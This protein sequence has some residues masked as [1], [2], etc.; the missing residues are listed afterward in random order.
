MTSRSARSAV[1]KTSPAPLRARR[2]RRPSFRC[3]RAGT[4]PPPPR[5]RERALYRHARLSAHPHCS[6][7]SNPKTPRQGPRR[8]I[9]QAI[10]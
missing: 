5:S 7:P 10:R 6:R 8:E 2:Q 1:R 4:S 9:S 3:W